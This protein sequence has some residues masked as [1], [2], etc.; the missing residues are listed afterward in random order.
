MI[1]THEMVELELAQ[2]FVTNRG[3]IARVRQLVVRIVWE[4]LV[5]LGAAVLADDLDAP[6]VAAVLERCRPILRHAS[7]ASVDGPLDEVEA[8]VPG[9]AVLAAVDIALHDLAGRAAGQPLHEL[10]GI[11]RPADSLTATSLGALP[12]RDFLAAFSKVA[13]WP[14]LK[15]KLVAGDRGLERVEALR[16]IYGGRIW[17]DGNGAWDRDGAARAADR[18]ADLGVELLE[19]P[20]CAGHADDL[21]WVRERSAIPIVADE[22]CSGPA[23]AARLA[24]CADVL[25]VKVGKC[26]GLRRSLATIQAARR[27]GMAVMIGCR[28]ESVL[29]ITATAQLGGL[30]DH[31]D[32]D[33]HLDVR[34]DPFS[35]IVV[36]RGT[37]TIS[38]AAGIGVQELA[39]A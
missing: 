29:G 34:D 21:R 15:L 22:D 17:V 32:L 28:T 27:E 1:L 31:F 12:A 38:R 23:D 24:G 25:N 16:D 36:D 18:C 4:D 11:P 26:G 3:R 35:G 8:L 33:G 14:I 9:A 30:A 37:V 39:R 6:H 13:D 5:G 7:P 2:P 10:W 19:Q 20:I